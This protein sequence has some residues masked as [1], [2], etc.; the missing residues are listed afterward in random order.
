MLL[1]DCL[2]QNFP[3]HTIVYKG[4]NLLA[5]AL[6]IDKVLDESSPVRQMLSEGFPVAP[7]ALVSKAFG[8]AVLHAI[9]QENIEGLRLCLRYYSLADLT[10]EDKAIRSA[11]QK[12]YRRA[13][14]EAILEER[15]VQAE[16][17]DLEQELSLVSPAIHQQTARM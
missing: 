11:I 5:W 15:W 17:R 7:T 13:D 3:V 14:F 9:H 12:S 10:Q 16:A 6:S 4:S 8:S 1:Q 2:D